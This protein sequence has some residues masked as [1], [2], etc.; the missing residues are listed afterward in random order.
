M[1]IEKGAAI[2]VINLDATF[3]VDLTQKSNRLKLGGENGHI[4]IVKVFAAFDNYSV[5]NQKKKILADELSR[6]IWDLREK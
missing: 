6:M 4:R 1:F 5:I 3:A 2:V